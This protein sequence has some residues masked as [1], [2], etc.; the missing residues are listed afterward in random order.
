VAVIVQGEAWQFKKWPYKDTVSLFAN[1]RGFFI[2]FKDEIVPALVKES[3][4]TTLTLSHDKR[5]LD[6][7]VS[8][9]FWKIVEHFVMHNKRGLI[10]Q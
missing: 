4:M 3:D 2:G 5:Y 10:G 9:E 8:N 7:K 1:V 6:A